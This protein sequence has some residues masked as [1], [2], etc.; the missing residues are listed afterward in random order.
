MWLSE[1][2]KFQEVLRM[3]LTPLDQAL[4]KDKASSPPAIGVVTGHLPHLPGHLEPLES[5]P[6]AQCG[7]GRSGRGST[8]STL[9]FT[10]PPSTTSSLTTSPRVGKLGQVQE[11]ALLLEH[12]ERQSCASRLSSVG[13]Y[14]Q[15]SITFLSP[16]KCDSL[17]FLDSRNMEAGRTSQQS[18]M[19]QLHRMLQTDVVESGES[20]VLYASG[21]PMAGR[22]PQSLKEA[23]S[24]RRIPSK[25]STKPD[26]NSLPLTPGRLDVG[27]KGHL[28]PGQAPLSASGSSSSLAPSM[29]MMT[30]GSSNVDSLDSAGAQKRLQIRNSSKPSSSCSLRTPRGESSPLTSFGSRMRCSIAD[31]N[32][33]ARISQVTGVFGMRASRSSGVKEFGTPTASVTIA[34]SISLRRRLWLWCGRQRKKIAPDARWLLK[35]K[36]FQFVM[37]FALISALFL[38]DLWIVMDRPNNNDLD[39]ILT[40]VLIL[41]LGELVVQSIG[42]MR[43]YWGSFFFWMDCIGA[44]SLLVD[45]SY[46]PFMALLEGGDNQDVSNNVIIMRAARIAKLGARAG[47]FTKLVKL[48]RFLPGMSQETG[49]GEFTAKVITTKL[50]TALSTRVS[51]LI[52]ILVMI[53]PFFSLWSYP[54][55]DWSMMA[56]MELLES[57]GLTNSSSRLEEQVRQF[58]NAYRERSYFPYQ[59]I[60]NFP[61]MVEKTWDFRYD[62]RGPPARKASTQRISKGDYLKCEFNFFG[63]QQMDA[64][65]NMALVAVIMLLM[66][67]FSLQM[68]VSISRIVLRP[69]ESLLKQVKEAATKIYKSVTDMQ[70][71]V[72]EDANQSVS[73]IDDDSDAGETHGFQNETALLEK[74]VEKLAV[75]G[76]LMVQKE[77]VNK[78]DLLAMSENDRQMIDQYRAARSDTMKFGTTTT[79]KDNEAGEDVDNDKVVKSQ[80]A[81]LTNAGLSL[82]LINSWNFNPLEI[83][84]ARCHAAA[85]FFLGPHNHGVEFDSL[86]MSDFLWACESNYTSVPYHTWFHAVD[87]T[88]TVYRLMQQILCSEAYLSGQERF[89]ILASAIS[90][91]LGHHGYNNPFLIETSHEL[92]LRYNDSSPLENMHCARFFEIVAIPR[93]NIFAELDRKEFQDVRKVCIEVILHTDAK[94]H[95]DMVKEVQVLYE[96][97]SDLLSESRESYRASDQKDFPSKDVTEVFRQTDT[98]QLLRKLFLHTADI[99]NPMKPFRICRIWAWKI[100]EEMFIQGDKELELAIPVQA[101]NNRE[102]V[103]RPMSQVG[104]IEFLVAPLAFAFAKVIPPF[105]GCLEQLIDNVK[106]WQEVWV[107]E[108][109][110]NDDERKPVEERVAKLEKRFLGGAY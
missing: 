103:N 48:L 63:P 17:E 23:I 96:V 7:L 72:G 3:S 36:S 75:L 34:P 12:N 20:G 90:H 70:D 27:E 94:K 109:Q 69:L 71:M 15:D 25:G 86:V 87:V 24:M 91:D 107:T 51:C 30:P 59:L 31:L 83:D 19:S 40:F 38:P 13:A 108:T 97:N 81:M 92:A 53:M 11:G 76:T 37:L 110:P 28:L 88:H 89:A 82:D 2:A 79:E 29:S 43:T 60:A 33:G 50:L 39:V 74:V 80:E 73:G 105:D 32:V 49:K 58:E 84:K 26:R 6:H 100:L 10:H 102:K 104:F 68:S 5:P 4:S 1:A 47:R 14:S 54:E 22:G 62:D 35:T 99:S 98:R 46:L 64:A 45:L 77:G 78:E 95:F 66:V 65:M 18:L 42:L 9:D 56:W 93:T 57:A 41:F 44:C 8:E 61:G 21:A 55:Q 85:M 52:I 67:V 106:R 101:L 16:G